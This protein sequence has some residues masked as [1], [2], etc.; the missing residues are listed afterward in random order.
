MLPAPRASA[1]VA[2]LEC[3][4]IYKWENSDHSPYKPVLKVANR[5][6]RNDATKAQKTAVLTKSLTVQNL[7]LKA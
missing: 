7:S 4:A 5:K 1:I 3:I 6:S 2:N